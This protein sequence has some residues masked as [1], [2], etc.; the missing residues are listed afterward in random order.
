MILW[1][2]Q[3]RVISVAAQFITLEAALRY[4]YSAARPDFDEAFFGYTK[5]EVSA[6]FEFRLNELEA[7]MSLMLLTAVEAALRIDFSTRV[8]LRGKDRVSRKFRRIQKA[9]K[10]KIRLDEDILE[11]WKSCHPEFSLLISQLRSA[12]KYRHWLA[13]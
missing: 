3:S 9:Q 11:V 7:V 12:M 2:D 8:L 1:P 10:Q 13:H 6:E 4:Y 5:D